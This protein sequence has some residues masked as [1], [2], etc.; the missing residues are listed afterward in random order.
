[1][2]EAEQRAQAEAQAQVQAMIKELK[3]QMPQ[4]QRS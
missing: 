3:A 2:F 4:F 1:V